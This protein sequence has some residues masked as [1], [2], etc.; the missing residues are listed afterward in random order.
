LEP[1]KVV[2][3]DAV[4]GEALLRSSEPAQRGDKLFYYEVLLKGTHAA[5]VRRYQALAEGIGRREQVAFALTQ[6]A[7]TKL[8][9]DL[10][11]DE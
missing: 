2:E 10:A 8:V 5:Q 11:G 7:L 1:L 6:E 3:V 4:K 9:G